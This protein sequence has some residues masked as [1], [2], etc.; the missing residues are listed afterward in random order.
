MRFFS[1]KFRIGL[2][3]N[4]RKRAK[5]KIT[6]RHILTKRYQSL[7]IC[8]G[9]PQKRKTGVYYI[10]TKNIQGL[11]KWPDT[12]WNQ[13]PPAIPSSL[14]CIGH[15]LMGMRC[16]LKSGLHPWWDSL[17]GNCFFICQ[18]LLIGDRDG[19][20]CPLLL[21][22]LGLCLVQTPAE[23]VRT[24]TV[25]KVHL[26]IDLLDLEGLPW[27]PP[28]R[29]ALRIF[30]P[31]LPQSF[32]SSTSHLELSI[33]KSLTLCISSVCGYQLGITS[34]LG[35]RVCVHFPSQCL[36]PSVSDLCR[37]HACYHHLYEFIG[38]TLLLYLEGLVSLVSSI[39]SGS[40][41]LSASFSTEVPELWEEKFYGD[42]SFREEYSKVSCSLYI[43]WLW[44][45]VCVSIC[46]RRRLLWWWINKALFDDYSRMLLGVILSLYS[47]TEELY[48][49]F[50]LVSGLSSLRFLANQVVSNMGSISWSQP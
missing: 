49:V 29:L 39:T 14:F 20:L 23:P 12:T 18:W 21:S 34:E 28:S 17:G 35:M 26:Y 4:S 27:S 50:H 33:P 24:A 43:V 32:M 41:H 25:S 47:L 13:E 5:E 40:Y 45:F 9:I 44:V 8:T 42:T 11:K 6:R 22:V 7:C 36:D 10:Y 38:V 46:C 1:L 2:T 19:G 30:S 15:L 16:S 37:L 3:N 48:L 31:A